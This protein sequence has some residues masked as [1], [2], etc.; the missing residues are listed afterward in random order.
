MTRPA[1]VLDACTLIPI[2]LAT[3]LL[4]LGDAGLLQP[5]WSDRILDEVQRNLPK[6]ADSMTPQRAAH[7]VGLMRDAFG[8]EAMVEGFDTLID[9]ME[10]DPKDR[11]VL[12]AAVRG[13]ADAIVTFNLK[14]FPEEAATPHGVDVIHPDAFLTRLLAE[15]PPSVVDV[16]R[17]EVSAFRNP[18]ESLREFL[19]SLTVTASTFANLAADAADERAARTGTLPALVQPE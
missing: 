17:R 12:A 5:L 18:P 11:H 14:D 19:A 8:V 10:C 15:N 7:R 16:L 13:G 9:T 3:T 1:V 6:V 4:W 2:R